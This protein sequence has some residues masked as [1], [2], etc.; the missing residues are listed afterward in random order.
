M[1]PHHP[2]PPSNCLAFCN[3][4]VRCTAP[5]VRVGAAGRPVIQL[6]EGFHDITIFDG[7][8]EIRSFHGGELVRRR[9][10]E[11]FSA[12]PGLFQNGIQMGHTIG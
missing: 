1:Y 6:C 9:G 10:F 7:C 3:A 5:G 8:A 2:T 12:L 4:V 11:V